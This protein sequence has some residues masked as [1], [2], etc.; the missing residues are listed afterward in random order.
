MSQIECKN[1]PEKRSEE[2]NPVTT[3]T[4]GLRTSDPGLVEQRFVYS[5]P[6]LSGGN[7]GGVPSTLRT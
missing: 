5:F 1:Q 4:L 3:A 7:G 6:F 2:I